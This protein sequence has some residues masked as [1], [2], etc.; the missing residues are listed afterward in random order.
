MYNDTSNKMVKCPYNS[1][2]VL[3]KL[4]LQSHL[5]K[6][7][8]QYPE[9]ELTACFFNYTHLLRPDEMTKHLEMCPDKLR[10]EGSRYND[11]DPKMQ[12]SHMMAVDESNVSHQSDDGSVMSS[13]TGGGACK[14]SN[15]LIRSGPRGLSSRYSMSQRRYELA[16]A[17]T[18][19]L[20]S[21]D[22][23]SAFQSERSFPY[24]CSWQTNQS[25]A[26][27][28]CESPSSVNSGLSLAMTLGATAEMEEPVRKNEP[29]V[30]YDKFLFNQD[31]ELEKKK[32][33]LSDI[34]RQNF[35]QQFKNPKS[36]GR[37][38]LLKPDIDP[39]WQRNSFSSSVEAA[40][41]T[42]IH[43]LFVGGYSTN[44]SDEEERYEDSNNEAD[45]PF[46]A[47][48]EKYIKSNIKPKSRTSE[49]FSGNLLVNNTYYWYFL[50]WIMV[51]RCRASAKSLIIQKRL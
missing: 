37:G 27:E 28:R 39:Q 40:A 43:K 25:K 2:H 19:L 46:L 30:D 33:S 48:I 12:F 44:E 5:I 18:D 35:F 16:N 22:N 7:R 45:N 6:C 42:N 51:Y 32:G 41:R 49:R 29:V 34:K 21:Y 17:E 23:I 4:R 20:Q 13:I 14:R 15:A 36:K 24:S 3:N 38:M 9:V 47:S 31:S 26:E 50:I 10:I 1:A 11:D 8:K